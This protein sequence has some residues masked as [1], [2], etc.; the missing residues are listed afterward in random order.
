ME[1]I[2]DCVPSVSVIIPAKDALTTIGYAIESALDQVGVERLEVIVIDDGSSDGMALYIS[3]SYP[4]VKLLLSR[5]RGVSAARNV[6][7][8]SCKGRYVAFL[9]A[10]DTWKNGKLARQVDFLDRNLDYVLSACVAEYVDADGCFIGVGAKKFDGVA[11]NALLGG[12]FIV[13]SSVVLRQSV[14]KREGI[15]F[16]EGLVFG[17]DWQMWI[18]LSLH[19]KFNVIPTPLV[20]YTCYPAKKYDVEFLTGSLQ[21][22]IKSLKDDPKL[23]FALS[24]REHLLDFIPALAR[25]SWIR[26]AHGIRAAIVEAI[27]LLKKYP[28]SFIRVMRN[29]FCLF[30][31]VN[32][33]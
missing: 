24:T 11:T 14:I 2:L 27:Q 13:T 30:L 10:D 9:D 6:G 8:A 33:R 20:R 16:N 25:L 1:D 32:I 22:M 31:V 17:E 4:S 3:E 29:L 28:K 5:G 7:L 23:A 18:K 19:G 26:Q 15:N 12:N 21:E